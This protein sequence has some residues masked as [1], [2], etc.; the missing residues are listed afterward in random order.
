MYGVVRS[1]KR[2]HFAQM[3]RRSLPNVIYYVSLPSYLRPG[4]G[5]YYYFFFNSGIKNVTS[6]NIYL[7]RENEYVR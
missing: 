4:I 5:L 3:D 2:L 6:L 1:G 7:K